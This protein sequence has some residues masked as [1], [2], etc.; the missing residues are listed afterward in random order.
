MRSV[1]G[2]LCI[3]SSKRFGMSL[4]S[5]LCSHRLKSL[6]KG[7]RRAD[8]C[9]V[10][11]WRS[12]GEVFLG[13]GARSGTVLIWKCL[14]YW[15]INS[16]LDSFNFQELSFLTMNNVSAETLISSGVDAFL[17]VKEQD[18]NSCVSGEDV[19]HELAII[20]DATLQVEN[21]IRE[22]DANNPSSKDSDDNLE[23]KNIA[24]DLNAN[25]GDSLAGVGRQLSKCA[26]FPKPGYM[27]SRLGEG[28]DNASF[29]RSVSLPTPRKLVS[30]MKGSREEGAPL[31]KL[32]VSW[33]PDVYD[34]PP[35]SVSHLPKKKT[36]QQF[37]NNKKHGKGKQ[38]GKNMR[39]GGGSP[40]DKKHNRK[41]S[42]TSEGYSV[43]FVDADLALP[44]NT[45][46]SVSPVD[47]DNGEDSSD[48]SCASSFLRK[49]CGTLRV[50]YAE[51]M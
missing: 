24:R 2:G 27:S 16:V 1:L 23:D 17:E 32:S 30:A 3:C 5:S 7:D 39:N 50:A 21:V 11:C 4:H 40:K 29:S 42:G 48:S 20:F 49:S 10:R 19:T 31:K 22:S 47:F 15:L 9:F 44:R 14:S 12:L 35:T 37:K 25:S 6:E 38:K 8:P 28:E 45:K 26:T 18:P 13:V 46:S 51:A 33:A 34:P 43:S 41:V 36:Q